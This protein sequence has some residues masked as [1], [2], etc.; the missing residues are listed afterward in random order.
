MFAVSS[1]PEFPF[2]EKQGPA[3]QTLE[4]LPV[5]LDDDG[6]HAVR[7]HRADEFHSQ[8]LRRLVQSR[9]R[10]IREQDGGR[11]YKIAAQQ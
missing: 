1:I 7:D 6:S 5:V 10:L 3:A 2:V 9:H 4:C 8:F 11:T